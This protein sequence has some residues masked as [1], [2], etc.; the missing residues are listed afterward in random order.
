[1]RHKNVSYVLVMCFVL[2][3][4]L[5]LPAYA[6]ALCTRAVLFV[7]DWRYILQGISLSKH[8]CMAVLQG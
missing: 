6:I 4:M 3:P 5:G 7:K 1:M 8:C 2:G